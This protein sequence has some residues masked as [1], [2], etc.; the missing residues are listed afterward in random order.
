MFGTTAFIIE[1]NNRLRDRCPRAWMG[2]W[3]KLAQ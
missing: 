3:R 1:W 2:I